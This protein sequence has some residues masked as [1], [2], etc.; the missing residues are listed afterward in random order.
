M[1][2]IKTKYDSKRQDLQQ[3]N[4]KVEEKTKLLQEAK[5]AYSKILENANMVIEAIDN[6]NEEH[7][8]K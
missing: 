7:S 5:K 4:V 3:L 2:L 8:I 6:E 1:Q